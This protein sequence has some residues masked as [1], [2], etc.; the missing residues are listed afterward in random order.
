MKQSGPAVSAAGERPD[1]VTLIAISCL[2][3][4]VAVALHEHA[5]HSAA[6]VLL[7]SDV[8]EMGAFYVECDDTRLSDLNLRLVALAGPVVSMLTGIAGFLIAERL[9]RSSRAGYYF[10][11]L[12]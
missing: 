6:C 10:A 4:V 1:A 8:K 3:Y 2:A 11:W 9:P 7:G 12:L 5:G